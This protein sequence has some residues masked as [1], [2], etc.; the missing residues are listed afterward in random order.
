[1]NLRTGNQAQWRA[2]Y[3]KASFFISILEMEVI[4]YMKI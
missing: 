4:G 2:L 1:M 3:K